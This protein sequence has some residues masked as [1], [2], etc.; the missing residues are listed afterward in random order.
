M[1]LAR[2]VVLAASLCGCRFGAIDLIQ[3]LLRW[4]AVE[5]FAL[6]FWQF[7]WQYCPLMVC[8]VVGYAAAAVDDGD[9]DVP[10]RSH[11][12]QAGLRV[13]IVVW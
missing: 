11:V 8:C 9:D 1:Q 6:F 7:I 3:S 13:V 4:L 12:L 5:A 10:F 2:T